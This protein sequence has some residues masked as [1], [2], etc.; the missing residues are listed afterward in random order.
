M[1][2]PSIMGVASMATGLADAFGQQS[3]QKQQEEE[4]KKWMAMQDKNRAEENA[5]Q[6]R[7]RLQAEAAQVQGLNK[8]SGASQA[9]QQGLEQSRL[10]DVFTNASDLTRDFTG[11]A[12]TDTMAG[13]AGADTLTSVADKYLLQ[14]QAALGK[15][16]PTFMSDLAGKLSGAAKDARTRIS[17]MATLSSYGPSFGGLDQFSDKA[18]MDAG[19]TID[20]INNFRNGSMK[21]YGIKQAVDPKHVVYQSGLRL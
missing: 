4:Y 14:G 20:E 11:D 2:D 6:E 18:L 3:A 7:L 21:V 8:L 13:G 19:M 15:S 16:D 12:A 5:N 10:T 1:C 9:K 17:N